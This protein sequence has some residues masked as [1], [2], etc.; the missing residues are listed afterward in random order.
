[1]SLTLVARGE[2]MTHTFVSVNG[3]RPRPPTL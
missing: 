3:V 1:M 2:K